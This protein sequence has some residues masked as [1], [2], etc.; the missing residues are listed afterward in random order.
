VKVYSPGDYGE[1]WRQLRKSHFRTFYHFANYSL[2]YQ[3]Y[4]KNTGEQA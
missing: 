3:A 1:T 2:E 4:N